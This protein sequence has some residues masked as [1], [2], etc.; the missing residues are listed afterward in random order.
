MP[1]PTRGEGAP[2]RAGACSFFT[3]RP[4]PLIGSWIRNCAVH[5]FK[6]MRVVGFSPSP[7]VGEGG[8]AKRGRVRGCLR[9]KKSLIELA[10]TNPSSGAD[11]RPRHLLPQ[12]EF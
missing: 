7:L 8:L 6:R 12:G 3:P 5:R 9:G 10:E 1:S 4:R 2:M 11:F